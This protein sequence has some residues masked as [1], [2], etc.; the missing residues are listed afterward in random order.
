MWFFVFEMTENPSTQIGKSDVDSPKV[1]RLN[2]KN[3]RLTSISNIFSLFAGNI[4]N[5]LIELRNRK[6][7]SGTA[8]LYE[9]TLFDGKR[10]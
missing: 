9:L 8:I 3:A 1:L 7:P 5:Y 2:A 10:R 6:F 4:S